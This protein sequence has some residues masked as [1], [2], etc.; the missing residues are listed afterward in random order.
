MRAQLARHARRVLVQHARC[1]SFALYSTP[2]RRTLPP[3]SI[4]NGNSRRYLFEGLFQKAPREVREPEFEPGW[5]KI[6]VWRSR[7]LDN[8]RPPPTEELV[9]AWRSFFDGKMSSRRPLNG[10]QAMQCRRLLNYLVE[11]REASPESKSKLER[12]DI[13][14]ALDALAQLRPRERTQDHLEFARSIWSTLCSNNMDEAQWAPTG[15][16]W[17]QYLSILCAF[18]GSEEALDLLRAHW[19]EVVKRSDTFKRTPFLS[20]AQALASDGHEE[21]L[22]ELAQYA[23]ENGIPYGKRLQT[24][25]V[26]FFIQRNR[27][28]E[29]KAWFEKK[30]SSQQRSFE[31]Y[32]QLA[33]FAARHDLKDWAVPFFLE[34]GTGLT[35]QKTEK[36]Y[37]DAL[38]QGILILGKGLKEVE[39][40]MANMEKISKGILKADTSTINGLL[41][42]AIEMGD[43]ALVDEILP[44]AKTEGRELNGESHLILMKMHLL[45]GYLPGVQA[46]YKKVTHFEPWHAE[47]DLWWEF[48]QLFN[49]YL[50]ALCAQKTPDYK[51]IAEMLESSEEIQVLLDPETVA[52]LC[53]R[54]L[55]NEQHFEVMDVLSV[56]AFHYSAAERA[57]IQN[58]LVDFCINE[59]STSRAWTGYQ[60]LRQF[61][62]DLSF[63]HRVKLMDAFFERKRPDMATHVFG[64]M[65]QHRNNDYHPKRE[66]Y[67]SC[68]EGLSQSPDPEALEMVYNMF[69]MDM[70]VEPDTQLYT[71]LILAHAASDKPLQAID[72]WQLIASSPEG[73]TYTSLEAIFWALERSPRGAKKAHSIW[74]Q[75]ET[76]DVEIPPQVYNAYLGAMAGSGELEKV[77]GMITEMR[78]RTSSEPDDMTLGIAFNALPGQAMQEAFKKWAKAQYPEAWEV[79]EK[80]GKRLN[81][82]SLCQFKLNRVLRA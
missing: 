7:M 22:L 59:P 79:L 11:K 70:T 77:E 80:R 8:L 52:T 76:L 78:S 36:K 62:Q 32:P 51:L 48:S 23:E 12:S 16:K 44:L 27:P 5:M 58:A 1:P 10:T 30:I 21:K 13:V 33:H 19:K 46:A 54:F 50:V 56:H 65:R 6:M 14:K 20:V 73:P 47:P 40:M 37:W 24:I 35:G 42:A 18:G 41:R 74:K 64:H 34:L 53:I 82:D 26:S 67:I 75:L 63:E 71:S 66:T 60:L 17:P 72:F 39:V 28:A 38:F 68:F 43:S 61:F 69:K 49:E 45:S 57:V 81:R 9:Q 15:A 3:R 29:V 4:N 31:I 25:M 2:L 55:E